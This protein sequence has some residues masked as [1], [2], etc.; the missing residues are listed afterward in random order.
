MVFEKFQLLKIQFR[1]LFWAWGLDVFVED[2][3]PWFA[4]IVTCTLAFLASLL[5]VYSIVISYPNFLMML[6]TTTLWGAL[7]QVCNNFK[8]F[9]CETCFNVPN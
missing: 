2:Y 1:K 9:K 3:K 8:D 6:K 7:F 5:S 4:T